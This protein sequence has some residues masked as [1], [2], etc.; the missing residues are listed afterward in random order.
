MDTDV[1]PGRVSTTVTVFRIVK[2]LRE[3]DGARVTELAN[4]LDIATSTVHRHLSTLHDLE[5]VVKD[6]DIYRLS[7]KFLGLGEYTRDRRDA[8][9]MA[10]EKVSELAQATDERAQFIIEEHGQAV[11]V[12]RETG[13]HAVKADSG[14]G[15]RIPLHATAA[16][17]AILAD[18]PRERVDEIIDE[19]GLVAK[20]DNTTVDE[21]ELYEELETIRDRGYSFNKQESIDGLRAVGVVVKNENDSVLGALSVSGPTHRLKDDFFEEEVPHLLLGTANELEL[22]IKYD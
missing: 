20:T 11:Y 17:K 10:K 15:K 13:A 18:I 4:R 21:A 5:Y 16:G 9:K 22:N 3:T 12:F 8:Y 2:T 14:I 6:G 7:F 1:G 19:R